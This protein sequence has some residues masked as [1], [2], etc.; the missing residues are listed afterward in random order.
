V[1]AVRVVFALYL[2]IIVAGVGFYTVIG[3]V[4]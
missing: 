2:V 4:G 1:A 3:L